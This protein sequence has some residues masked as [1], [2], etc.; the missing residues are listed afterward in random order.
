[1]KRSSAPLTDNEKSMVISVY[2]YFSGVNFKTENHQK[3][4][5]RKRVSDALNISESMVG[6]VVVD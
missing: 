5:L 1:M 6:V 4:I 3:T 2:N